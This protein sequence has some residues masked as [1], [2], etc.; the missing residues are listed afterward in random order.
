MTHVRRILEILYDRGDAFVPTGELSDATGLVG[1]KLSRRLEELETQGHRLE[2][3]PAHGVKLLR[4]VRLDAHLIERRLRTRR[5]GKNVL[6]FDEVDSTNDVA[7]DSAR[8][9]GA[10]G[11]VV[12]AEHQRQGRGR[13]GKTWISPRGANIL[14]SVLLMEPQH[15]PH[16]AIT[17]AAG[18]A[19]AEGVA[20]AFGAECS[21]KWPNDVLLEGGKLAGVLVEVRRVSRR[22]CMVI[23]IGFNANASPTAR[24]VDAPP[25]N[26]RHFLGHE[27]ERI[28][29][30]RALLRRL[31]ARVEGVARGE[32]DELHSAWVVRCDMI[33]QR[34]TIL[35][36]GR[37]HVGRVLDVSPLEGLILACDDGRR[38]HLG[39]QGSSVL[40]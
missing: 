35:C 4:P 7:F 17:I 37:R 8:Q 6:C 32:L 2:H 30:V 14:M 39:A 28:E 1:E 11:L 40:K 38:L 20:D 13:Q 24:Q 15:L 34:H 5:V 23:G 36:D 10:D 26:L 21:L 3:S 18:L 25:M 22:T 9:S 19:V 31:D 16:D 12:L 27:V 33:N 29:L